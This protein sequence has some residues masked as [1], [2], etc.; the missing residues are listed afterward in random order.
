[1]IYHNLQKKS[2]WAC[3]YILNYPHI[4]MNYNLSWEMHQY[5]YGQVRQPC[6][7]HYSVFRN[8]HHLSKPFQAICCPMSIHQYS[9]SGLKWNAPNAF[10]ICHTCPSTQIL[11][12]QINLITIHGQTTSPHLV[13][14][15]WRGHYHSVHLKFMH[16]NQSDKWWK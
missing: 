3:F 11:W 14:T 6:V 12:C 15:S 9:K 4:H 1:M 7:L 5:C 2:P 16:I 10:H 13:N 8:H